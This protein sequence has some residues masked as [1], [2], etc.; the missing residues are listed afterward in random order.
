M[1]SV[2]RHNKCTNIYFHGPLIVFSVDISPTGAMATLKHLVLLFG[3]ASLVDCN[4]IGDC[5]LLKTVSLHTW[6]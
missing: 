3:I 4:S 2:C 6:Y 1:S 5:N